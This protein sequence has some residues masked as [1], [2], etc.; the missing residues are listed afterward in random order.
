MPPTDEPS[1][2]S[3][4]EERRARDIEVPIRLYKTVTVFSTLFAVL[5]VVGG[6]LVLDVA[7]QQSSLSAEEVNVPIAL[8]GIGLI[9]LGAVVYAFS[10]RFRAQGMGKSKDDADEPADNG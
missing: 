5:A 3:A 9:A 10:T 1:P 4:S 2:E 6:F 7:T 8:A